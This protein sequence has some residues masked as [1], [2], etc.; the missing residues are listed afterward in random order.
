M[1]FGTTVYEFPYQGVLNIALIY[2]LRKKT[3]SPHEMSVKPRDS[4]PINLSLT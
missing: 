3:L 2:P 1:G 4:G